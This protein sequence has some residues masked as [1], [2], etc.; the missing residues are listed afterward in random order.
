MSSF[1]KS[2]KDKLLFKFRKQKV[3]PVAIPKFKPAT[4]ISQDEAISLLTYQGKKYDEAIKEC[5]TQKERDKVREIFIR[6]SKK[7]C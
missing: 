6:F 5:T 3:K 7:P 1:N 2:N 4:G